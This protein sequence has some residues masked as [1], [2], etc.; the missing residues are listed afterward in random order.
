MLFTVREVA[1]MLRVNVSFV[2]KLIKKK[3]L[4]AVKLGS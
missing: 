1:T 2:Y 4:P 3:L